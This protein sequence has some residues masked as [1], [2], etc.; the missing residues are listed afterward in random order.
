MSSLPC[1]S[2]HCLR[3]LWTTVDAIFESWPHLHVKV[4]KVSI[5]RAPPKISNTS[6]YVRA[7]HDRSFNPLSKVPWRARPSPSLGPSTFSEYLHHVHPAMILLLVGVYAYVFRA[8]GYYLLCW[9]KELFR[10]LTKASAME[11]VTVSNFKHLAL[12]LC[13]M[14]NHR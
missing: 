10:N 6:A 1:C 11:E 4:T 13:I 9:K 8:K 14:C 2:R 7:R 3:Q 5:R 12:R